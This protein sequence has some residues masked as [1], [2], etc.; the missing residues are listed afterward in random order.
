MKKICALLLVVTMLFGSIETVNAKKVKFK[1]YIKDAKC[2]HFIEGDKYFFSA[3]GKI[4]KNST[5]YFK[6]QLNELGC[7][8]VGAC[9]RYSLNDITSKNNFYSKK[10]GSF[11]LS[12]DIKSTNC[13]KWIYVSL[14]SDSKDIWGDWIRIKKGKFYK[15]NKTIK[16]KS[17]NTYQ[18]PIS[19]F[20]EYGG[21]ICLL[22]YA[23]D[24]NPYSF[25]KGGK[26]YLANHPDKEI[27]TTIECKNISL[28]RKP[29]VPKAK[30]IDISKNKK[31]VIV[32]YKKINGCKYEIQISKEKK[33]KSKNTRTYSTS[34][35]SYKAKIKGKKLFVRI[36]P[37][38][39][40][41]GFKI[42]GKWTSAKT[43]K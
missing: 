27:P 25:I 37:Y 4:I 18:Y 12:F 40:Y 8:I 41:N 14:I 7:S 17:I 16:L 13:D 34:K 28:I 39:V 2:E 29:S 1:N 20:I 26:E 24:V 42:Y 10:D 35:A 5:C 23:N 21:E 11:I 32:K 36:R 31:N 38:Y 43:I 9:T 22:D 15:Y 19:L 30:I 3:K 6:S 33:F